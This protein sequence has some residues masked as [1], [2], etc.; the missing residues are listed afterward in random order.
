VFDSDVDSRINSETRIGQESML[1]QNR[2]ESVFLLRRSCGGGTASESRFWLAR[3][4]PTLNQVS[5]TCDSPSRCP[6]STTHFATNYIYAFQK[7]LVF[8]RT[9]RARRWHEKSRGMDAWWYWVANRNLMSHL[10]A[11]E[12]ADLSLKLQYGTIKKIHKS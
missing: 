6:Y 12:R 4:D 8:L 5:R 2:S 1:I 7:S 3:I 10:P 9:S 11:Q